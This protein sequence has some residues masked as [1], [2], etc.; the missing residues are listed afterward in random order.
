MVRALQQADVS[1]HDWHP[2][3]ILASR[4][5]NE[6]L[7]C[8]LVDFAR[9]T[10][11]IEPGVRHAADDVNN[12]LYVLCDEEDGLGL[13]GSLVYEHFRWREPWDT[14]WSYDP[15]DVRFESPDPFAF[16]YDMNNDE[17]H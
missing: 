1:Q 17:Q 10:F 4:H 16:V 2:G 7:H 8:V 5:E 14:R 15:D 12:C 13:P 9:A 3:Q 6:G 11:T